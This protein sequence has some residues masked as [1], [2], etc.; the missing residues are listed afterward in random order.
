MHACMHACMSY[1]SAELDN[2]RI[3][4]LRSL[5]LFQVVGGDSL[6]EAALRKVG[7][8]AYMSPELMRRVGVELSE[9][10]RA[11]EGGR[12]REGEKQGNV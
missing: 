1:L 3:H 2:S 10:K 12:E 4:L 7:T 6:L 5:Y 9:R 8:P 11:R